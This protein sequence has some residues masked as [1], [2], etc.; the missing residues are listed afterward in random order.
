MR[1]VVVAFREHGVAQGSA[2]ADILIGRHVYADAGLRWVATAF[3]CFPDCR[4]AASHSWNG[5]RCVLAERTN[6][7]VLFAASA[8]AIEPVTV[9]SLA[10]ELYAW[11][12]T[13]RGRKDAGF[14][15]FVATGA[16]PFRLVAVDTG[17]GRDEPTM[18]VLVPRARWWL[19][20]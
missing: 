13:R 20:G 17:L 5:S 8:A 2:S 18:D 12:G 1:D 9:E 4:I 15:E 14:S 11:V 7:T 19:W 3:R 10:R 16:R 6:P